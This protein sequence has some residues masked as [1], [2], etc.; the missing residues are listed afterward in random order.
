MRRVEYRVSPEAFAQVREKL[1]AAEIKG[2]S[3]TECAAIALTS[4][5]LGPCRWPPEPVETAFV[6]DYSRRGLVFPFMDAP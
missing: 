3:H 6:V 5:G 4:V 1:L 2:Y